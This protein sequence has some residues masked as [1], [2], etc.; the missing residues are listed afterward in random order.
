MEI[1]S[2]GEGPSR[3]ENGFLQSSVS[4]G[5]DLPWVSNGSIFMGFGSI[6]KGSDEESC[7]PHKL[8]TLRALSHLLHQLCL[9]QAR[10]YS[11]GEMFVCPWGRASHKSHSSVLPFATFSPLPFSFHPA[12]AIGAPSVPGDRSPAADKDLCGH[13]SSPEPGFQCSLRDQAVFPPR[14]RNSYC[15]S[16][17]LVVPRE[18]PAVRLPPVQGWRGWCGTAL[19]E[20]RV[21]FTHSFYCFSY[22]AKKKGNL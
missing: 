2:R 8:L 16:Q 1:C 7:F 17:L 13:R 9:P 21:N 20:G 14:S 11:G 15:M 5:N 6:R 22:C 3:T 19:R 4:V 18:V 12:P 10:V